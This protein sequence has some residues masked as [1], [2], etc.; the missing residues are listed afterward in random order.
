[1][2]IVSPETQMTL[3]DVAA[4]TYTMLTQPVV[5][6]A[7]QQPALITYSSSHQPPLS[8]HQIYMFIGPVTCNKSLS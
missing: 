1:M 4:V 3:L 6:A 8:E 5:R 2:C 7:Q